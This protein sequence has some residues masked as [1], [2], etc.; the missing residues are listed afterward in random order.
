MQN[1]IVTKTTSKQFTLNLNDVTKGLLMAV[2][3]AVISP[4]MESLNAGQLSIDW[5]HVAAGAITAGL[6]YILKNFFTPSQTIVKT[7]P[8]IEE[9]KTSL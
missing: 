8:P 1:Q 9:P 4:I 2:I 3:G 7:T 6:G 5:K